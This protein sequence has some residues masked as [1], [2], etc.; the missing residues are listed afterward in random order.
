MR[1]QEQMYHE[2]AGHTSRAY[3]AFEEIQQGPNPLTA[4]DI[5][6]LIARHPDRYG[7]M[8]PYAAQLDPTETDND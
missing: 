4:D 3:L 6:A 7:W 1:T 8:A 5:R 2:A